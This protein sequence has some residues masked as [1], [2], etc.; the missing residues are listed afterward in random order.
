MLDERTSRKIASLLPYILIILGSIFAFLPLLTGNVWP[1]SHDGMRYIFLFAE[2]KEAFLHGQIY[3]RWQANMYGGYGYP[4]FCFYQ[5]GYF[6]LLLFISIF[7]KNSIALFS[8]S[9]M[10]LFAI[11]GIGA[12]KLCLH[13]SDRVTSMII[14]AIYLCTPYI[15][16]NLFVR[17]DL[18]E[19]AAMLI[20]PWVFFLLLELKKKYTKQNF[21]GLLHCFMFLTIF[22]TCIIITHP[23][24]ALFIFPC[25]F[26]ISIATCFMDN[27]F[28]S[29][30]FKAFLLAHILSVILSS[31]YWITLFQLKTYASFDNSGD[32]FTRP[33][34]HIVYWSQ[35]FSN[36]WAYTFSNR[37]PIDG[38]SYQLGLIHFLLSFFGFLLARKNKIIA[39][40][41]C[42]Y[43]LLIFCMSPFSIW[44]WQ[45]APIITYIQF[46]W[47]ILS[48]TS[49]LQLL[50]MCGLG[51]FL[52]SKRSSIKYAVFLLI[53]ASTLIVHHKQ[54]TFIY[55]KTDIERSLE[56][57]KNLRLLK[58]TGLN[59]ENEFLPKDA[60][61]QKLRNAR[62]NLPMILT[63]SKV[64]TKALE[65]NNPY[66]IHYQFS[67]QKPFFLIINQ[68][69]FPGW[70]I[71]L[72]DEKLPTDMIE[73]TLSPAGLM[74]VKALPGK[75][76][77]LEAYYDGPPYRRTRTLVVVVLVGMIALLFVREFKYLIRKT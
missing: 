53:I 48:V 46:P 72:N 28:E 9:L 31:P 26:V 51:Y 1:Q 35:F 10:A 67:N 5:P 11:S 32:Y 64:E 17:G 66:H 62:M 69:Y 40:S 55:D 76:Q 2:F 58:F 25:V 73:R 59:A 4:S 21:L 29:K 13:F 19:L 74:V 70:V 65:G 3:P 63:S 39:A 34:D 18:S 41:F 30:L 68:F 47:R 7:I 56:G 71:K 61:L 75:D 14:T 60:N 24:T 36:K 8:V 50:C 16:V 20:S 77:T 12:Y 37:G 15:Y 45:H 6:Y 38:M 49:T 22:L 44:L 57:Y 42:L 43:I 52:S 23:A 54:F 27:R 33:F